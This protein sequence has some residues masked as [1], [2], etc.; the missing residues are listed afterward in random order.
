MT[1]HSPETTRFRCA[2]GVLAHESEQEAVLLNP[3]TGLYHSAND[4]G[5]FIWQRL[6]VSG[7]LTLVQICQEVESNFAAQPE[8]IRTDAEEFITE[9]A[10][11][12]L[13][14]PVA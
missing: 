4:V 12:G 2:V 6:S 10:T 13:V 8:Q 1:D 5:L 7:P 11:V 9:L 3:T 14:S